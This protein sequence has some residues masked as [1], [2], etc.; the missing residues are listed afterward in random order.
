M[1][2]FHVALGLK[3]GLGHLSRSITLAKYLKKK[4]NV[5]FLIPKDAVLARKILNQN[6]I[7]TFSFE[8]GKKIN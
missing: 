2:L 7:S 5:S 8:K 6:N 3:S 4:S 1:I